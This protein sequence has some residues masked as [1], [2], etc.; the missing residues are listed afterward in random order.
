MYFNHNRI[1]IVY[2]YQMKKRRKTVIKYAHDIYNWHAYA[3]L[4]DRD[5][6]DDVPLNF[7]PDLSSL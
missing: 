1:T 6:I 3:H 4:N 7:Q 5:E 2:G